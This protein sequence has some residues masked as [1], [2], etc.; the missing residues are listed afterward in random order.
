MRGGVDTT[1]ERNRLIVTIVGV[2]TEADP[3][4]FGRVLVAARSSPGCQAG[5]QVETCFD[6]GHGT[7]Y[8]G[9]WIGNTTTCGGNYHDASDGGQVMVTL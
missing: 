7:F 2:D 5:A 3:I 1:C 8:G 6:S 9:N 4:I